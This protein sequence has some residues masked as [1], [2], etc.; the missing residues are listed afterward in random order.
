VTLRE[1]IDQRARETFAAP[2]VPEDVRADNL[3]LALERDIREMDEA[4]D[5]LQDGLDVARKIIDRV[6]ARQAERSGA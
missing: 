4:L 2:F 6:G 5:A 1:Q 3:L